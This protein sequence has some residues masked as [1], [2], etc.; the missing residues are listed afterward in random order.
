LSSDVAEINGSRPS[1]RTNLANHG[2]ARSS[3]EEEDEHQEYVFAPEVAARLQEEYDEFATLHV[4]A[5][6]VLTEAIVAT[7]RLSTMLN[8]MKTFNS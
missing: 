3:S 4:N 1:S 2:E 6:V 7:D 8:Q 5:E